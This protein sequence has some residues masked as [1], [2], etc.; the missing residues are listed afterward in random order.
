MLKSIFG[1]FD[2]S[3]AAMDKKLAYFPDA[4][5]VNE[6]MDVNTLESDLVRRA[7][8]RVCKVRIYARG[9]SNIAALQDCLEVYREKHIKSSSIIYLVTHKETYEIGCTPGETTTLEL[10]AINEDLERIMAHRE[11]RKETVQ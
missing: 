6:Y 8:E 5:F 1:G 9:N 4:I 2:Y 7:N 3:D 10:V 11:K